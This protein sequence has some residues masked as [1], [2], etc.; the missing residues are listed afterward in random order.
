MVAG[1]ANGDAA[2]ELAPH[3][4]DEGSR[5]IVWSVWNQRVACSCCKAAPAAAGRREGLEGSDP[6]PES[7]FRSAGP[8]DSAGG[9]RGRGGP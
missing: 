7:R 5:S 4:P 6:L 3:E 1:I 2:S 9:R 8:P